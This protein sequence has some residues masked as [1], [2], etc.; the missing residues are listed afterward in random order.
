MN[1]LARPFLAAPPVSFVAL[2]GAISFSEPKLP[3]ARRR[4]LQVFASAAVIAAMTPSQAFAQ[5]TDFWKLPRSLWL[6]RQST[7]EEVRVVYHADGALISEGYTKLCLLMRDVNAGQ[8]VTMSPVLLDVLAGMQGMLKVWGCHRP[9]VTHSGFRSVHTNKLTEGA[10]RNSLHTYG[11]AWDGRV[12]GVDPSL[13]ARI[14]LYLRG[15]GVGLYETRGFLHVD[16][17]RL[18]QWRG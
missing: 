1:D 12:P 11:R 6:Q 16:D 17:G 10:A 13:L 15:G 14:A 7:G 4:M 5:S 3:V 8:A 18:R 9:L 2:E